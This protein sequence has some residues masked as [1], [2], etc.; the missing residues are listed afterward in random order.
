[1][2]DDGSEFEVELPPLNVKVTEIKD[3]RIIKMTVVK[4]AP[5]AEEEDEEEDSAK[6]KVSRPFKEVKK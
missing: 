5:P 6:D 1:M 4:T 3:H 2:S